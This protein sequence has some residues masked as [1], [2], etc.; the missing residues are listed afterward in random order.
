MS[1]RYPKP[2]ARLIEE[3]VR[4]PGIGPKTAQRL[5]LF[6][7]NQPPGEVESLAQAMVEAKRRIH[8]CSQCFHITEEDPCAILC[9][10]QAQPQVHL[11]GG[12]TPGCSG[13]GANQE[14]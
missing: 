8:Y 14:L 3:L 5:A 6:L 7:I 1:R 9:R 4:L 13:Y 2:L 11:R 10:S 12:R